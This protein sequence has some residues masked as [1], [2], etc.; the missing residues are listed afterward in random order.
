[1]CVNYGGKAEIVDAVSALAQDIKK[2]KLSPDK[3]TEKT[4][5]SYM[6]NPQ[7]S[8]V[9]LFLRSSGEM[10]T[11]NFLPW[12]SA[13]AEMVFLDVLWPDVNR[14]VLWEAIEIYSSRNRRFGKA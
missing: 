14:K 8:D 1:M 10:R 11:S 4:L 7:M 12:Q 9:D 2:K 5:S 3:I 6:Y 13:Y